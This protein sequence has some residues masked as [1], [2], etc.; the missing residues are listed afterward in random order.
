[1]SNC[2]VIPAAEMSLDLNEQI[3]EIIL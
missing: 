3:V 1:L 2:S